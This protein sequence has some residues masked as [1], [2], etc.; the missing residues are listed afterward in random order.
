MGTP[1]ED[2]VTGLTDRKP[3]EDRAK[4]IAK[5]TLPYLI[6]DDGASGST[7]LEDTQSQ[8]YGARLV[9]TL[10]AKMG[11]A[12][13]PPSTSSFRL[14]PDAKELMALTEGDPNNIAEVNNLLSTSTITINTELE[15]QQIRPTLYEMLAQLIVVGS[16]VTDK[17]KDKGI[18][19]HT[20]KSFVVKLDAQG[21]PLSIIIYEELA[22]E[23]LPE[24]VTP[25]DENLEKYGL[26]TRYKLEDVQN[27]KKW[28]MTQSI[29][30]VMV[31]TEKTFKD[32]DALPVRYFGWTWTVGDQYHRPYAEDYYK[33]LQQLDK[34]ANLLTD[35]SIISAKSLLL[36][37]ERGG[38]TRKDDVADSSNGDVIDGHAEDITAFQ[39]NKNYDFQT[40]M[41]RETNLKRELA[42]AFLLNES[43][44][45][46]AERVTA[47]EIRFMAQQ[48]ESSAL[49]GFYS[50]MALEWS[51]WI[52]QKI[53]GELGIKFQAINVNIITGLDALG[54]S[55]EAQKLD[56]Y[57]M[58]L[59]Q[60]NMMHWI[61]EAEVASRYAAYEGIDTVGLVKT[62]KEVEETMAQQQEMQASQEAQAAAAQA[63][64]AA[65][66]Q[67]AAQPPEGLPQ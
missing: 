54:R 59:D 52:V 13:L 46:E 6:R 57:L 8:S 1:K 2:Y 42:A 48:L 25:E 60:M 41:E 32:Y 47:E 21:K 5:V 22:K 30:D 9:N 56:A 38:R 18:R 28:I 45:R 26:Y 35:G 37:N 40:P 20:L 50:T 66:G 14:T 49:S 61:N 64:G 39:F 34:M 27:A 17:K 24:G 63:G 23:R 16:V 29:E 55:Q 58:R 3:Y 7:E 10:K 53:M 33:D 44:T 4:E 12:L 15:S 62:P 43:A 51:K 11:M 36:V 31:G 67:A 65:A 19:L